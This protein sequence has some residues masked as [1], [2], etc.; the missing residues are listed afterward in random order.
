VRWE[1]YFAAKILVR[2]NLTIW[3]AASYCTR[4]ARYDRYGGVT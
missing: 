4:V 1:G 2:R 3:D